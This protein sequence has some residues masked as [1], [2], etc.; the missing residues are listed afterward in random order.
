MTDA[1]VKSWFAEYLSTFA[2]CGRGERELN[3]LLGYYG[4][5]ILVTTDGGS[6]ALT[7]DAQ[8]L[9]MAKQQIDGMRAQYDH[10]DL[11]EASVSVVNASSALY[12]GEFAR[13]RKDGTE[14]N[15]LLVSYLITEGASGRRI[16]ALLVHHR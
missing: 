14:I 13:V 3:A 11:L 1:D 8:V 15:R 7:S 6:S 16:S 12:R 5:P 9:A 2:A 10:S 4:V